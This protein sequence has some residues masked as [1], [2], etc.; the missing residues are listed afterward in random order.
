M[1]LLF[2]SCFC[3]EK[4]KTHVLTTLISLLQ[5]DSTDDEEE[6]LYLRSNASE[7]DLAEKDRSEADENDIDSTSDKTQCT[8]ENTVSPLQMPLSRAA[9]RGF[10]QELTALEI[11]CK[12]SLLEK[13]M[14]ENR[15][16]ESSSDDFTPE[17]PT[18]VDETAEEFYTPQLNFHATNNSKAAE[19]YEMKEETVPEES[20]SQ[21]IN[22]HKET[23][24]F[25]LGKQLSCNWSTGA[26]PRIGCLRD[27][28][29]RLQCH[30]LE[31]VNLSPRS[32]LQLRLD[33]PSRAESRRSG[34]ILS[35]RTSLQHSTMQS[36]LVHSLT[37]S[38]F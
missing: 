8:E 23:K 31:E 20:I 7:D 28:P 9:S 4:S 26:G 22:L 12:D 19:V 5:L 35:C 10:S 2:I 3:C 24:S 25:Q 27:Y 38:S 36:S 15:R 17:S 16:A 1:L 21:R 30:A 32:K 34:S 14:M 29:T 11:P 6:G 13:L 33:S 37:S 18:D